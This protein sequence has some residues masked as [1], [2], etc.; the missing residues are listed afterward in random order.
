M[1]GAQSLTDARRPYALHC[2][3]EVWVWEED[4]DAATLTEAVT[5]ARK[6]LEAVV[7]EEQPQLACVTLV[8][9]DR[10]LGVWDWVVDQAVWTAI[11]SSSPPIA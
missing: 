5:V 10:K 3:T 11:D 4:I 6:A 8:K 2:L 7:R 9:E 1:P